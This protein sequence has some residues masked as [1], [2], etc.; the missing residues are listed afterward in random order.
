MSREIEIEKEPRAIFISH[1]YTSINPLIARVTES[2]LKTTLITTILYITSSTRSEVADYQSYLWEYSQP[3]F[4]PHFSSSLAHERT[5]ISNSDD[6]KRY[7]GN[8]QKDEER[9]SER[10]KE[11]TIGEH[12]EKHRGIVREG[13]S[14]FVFESSPTILLSFDRSSS[15]ALTCSLGKCILRQKFDV[16]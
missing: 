10:E 15:Y 4:L 5:E 6:S 2:L 14:K 16:A 7:F 11:K 1:I 13:S 9:G 12:I 3:R 8:I